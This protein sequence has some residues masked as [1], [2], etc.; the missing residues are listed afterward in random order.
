M[1]QYAA[2][3]GSQGTEE[4]EEEEEEEGLFK[5]DAVRRRGF[6]LPITSDR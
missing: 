3:I 4:E 5:A 6:R 2:V 1:R